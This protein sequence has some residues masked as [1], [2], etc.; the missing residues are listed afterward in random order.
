M[1]GQNLELSELSIR[2]AS[3]VHAWPS[4][5]VVNRPT[6]NPDQRK[7]AA[8]SNQLG[9]GNRPVSS[10][11]LYGLYREVLHSMFETVRVLRK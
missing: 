1:T 11:Y 2:F 3:A 6:A 8:E 7:Y 5:R 4:W 10:G 9:G